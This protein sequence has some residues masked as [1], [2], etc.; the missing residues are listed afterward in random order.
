MQGSHD[1]R[2]ALAACSARKHLAAQRW[3]TH[4]V[5]LATCEGLERSATIISGAAA[6]SSCSMLCGE[7]PRAIEEYKTAVSAFSGHFWCCRRKHKYLWIRPKKHS[8]VDRRRPSQKWSSWTSFDRAR[9]R[10]GSFAGRTTGLCSKPLWGPLVWWA[11]ARFDNAIGEW[12]PEL[13]DHWG[14]AAGN[15]A[16]VPPS[17]VRLPPDVPGKEDQLDAIRG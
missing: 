8:A 6:S 5:E 9:T 10:C 13:P 16:F 17:G 1:A 4:F 11:R 14:G 12:A 3:R 7:A 2:S 15:L